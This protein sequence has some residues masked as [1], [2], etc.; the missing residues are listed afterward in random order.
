MYGDQKLAT[1]LPEV[2]KVGAAA[3]D[4]WPQVHGNQREQ[5]EELGEDEFAAM[6]RR[7]QVTL[8]CITQYPL[9]PFGLQEELKFASR[10]QCP[11]I[12][13]G[14]AGPRGLSGPALKEAVQQFAR[15]LQPQLQLAAAAGVTIA[16]ENHHNSLIETPDS[17]RWLIEC[18]ESPQLGIALAPYHLPQDADLIARLVA[19][20]D[21][22][23]AVFYAWQHGLG[24][25]EK[26][27]KEQELLQLPGR[28]P[29]DFQPIMKSLADIHYQGWLSIFMHPV[30]RGIPILDTTDE[31]TAEINRARRYLES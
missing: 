31:V 11:T 15:Q 30:P 24:C 2:T 4:I 3:I 8:G 18:C 13:T 17:I 5:I 7:H 20:C 19:D 16:I 26:L 9:G 10:F 25:T 28:G 21:H 22:R 12:V 27:P 1:I 29:L 14:A 6:L 23:L